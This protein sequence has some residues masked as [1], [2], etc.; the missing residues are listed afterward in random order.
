MVP[1]FLIETKAFFSALQKAYCKSY[2]VGIWQPHSY[3]NFHF[4][5]EQYEEMLFQRYVEGW[6]WRCITCNLTFSTNHFTVYPKQQTQ[7]ARNIEKDTKFYSI[8]TFTLN[9]LMFFYLFK[10]IFNSTGLYVYN[11]NQRNQDSY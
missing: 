10:I 6:I 1:P 4:V 5:T 2:Y 3:W 8:R 9:C 7:W 11:V